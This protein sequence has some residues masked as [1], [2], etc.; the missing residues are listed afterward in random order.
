MQYA[1]FDMDGTLI[2]SMPAWIRLGGDYLRSKG[3]EP[4]VKR[5]RPG[6]FMIPEV[7]PLVFSVKCRTL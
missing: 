6:K 1:I 7:I 2:D 4:P 5:K 3:I